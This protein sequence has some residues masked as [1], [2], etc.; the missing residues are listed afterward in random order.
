MDIKRI[1]LVATKM[2]GSGEV[3]NNLPGSPSDR[4]HEIN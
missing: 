2:A 3:L 4:L 1:G